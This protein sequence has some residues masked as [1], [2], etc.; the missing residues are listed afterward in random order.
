MAI[1]MAA[2]DK[3]LVSSSEIFVMISLKTMKHALIAASLFMTSTASANSIGL[4]FVDNGNGG[5]QNGAADALGAAE[6]AGAPGYRRSNWNNLGRW[7]QTVSLIDNSGAGSGVT[8]TWDSNN[9]WRTGSGTGTPDNKLMHGYLDSTG[10]ANWETMPYQFFW[11]ENKPEV[12]I[13]NV[14][15]WLAGQGGA[16]QY[17]VVVYIDGDTTSGRIGEYWLQN[18]SGGDPPTLLGTD[19]TTHVFVQDSAN[20]SGTYTQTPLSANS[21]AGA[22]NGN[23]VVFTGLSANSFILR[24][25][26]QNVRSQINAIQIVPVTAVLRPGD[27]DGDDDVDLADF[28]AIRDHF[29]MTVA[30]RSLGDVNEDGYVDLLD[31]RVWKANYPF[32]GA[33]AG[34]SE[35]AT[36]PE[37]SSW[38][39]GL[40]AGSLVLG[41]GRN[42]R[43]CAGAQ[44]A[45]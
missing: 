44:R 4:N 28:A 29:E 38:I 27:V 26:E 16:T 12:Y 20:F 8:V 40:I 2:S 32:P 21:V 17:D 25:E 43:R 22:A 30:S 15:S 39:F 1:A 19:L 23:Y 42:T 36:I 7:G 6:V 34:A 24:T 31:F 11:N 3:Q 5:V 13:N 14:S 10:Q 18:G 37:P 35:N 45:M 41:G 33:G 9:T